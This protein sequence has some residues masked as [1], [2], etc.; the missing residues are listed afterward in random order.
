LLAQ[1][2]PMKKENI[3]GADLLDRT[4][5][6]V[7]LQTGEWPA[8]GPRQVVQGRVSL[9]IYSSHGARVVPLEEGGTLVVGRLPPADVIVRDQNLSRQHARVVLRQGWIWVED[10]DSTNGTWVN[11][12]RIDVPTPLTKNDELAFGSVTASVQD[13]NPADRQCFAW[14]G[15]DDFQV[16]LTSE[17]SRARNFSRAIALLMVRPDRRQP[18]PLNRWFSLLRARLRP[19][20]RAALYSVDT[21]EIALP[22]LTVAQAEELARSMV[23][24]EPVLRCGVGVFPRHASSP[25]E[26]LEVTRVS[27]Q[28]ATSDQ[29]VCSAAERSASGHQGA[30]P[31]VS[32]APVVRSPALKAVYSMAERVASSSI[33]VLVLGETGTGKEHLARAIHERGK[34]AAKP[35]ICVNCG[36]IPS[37]LVESTLFGHERGAFTGAAQQAKGVFESAH[38]GTV[39][40]DEIGELSAVAQAALL[41]VL[42]SKCFTRVGST[43]EVKVDVRVVAA[44][45]RSLEEMVEKGE[46]RADLLYRLNGMKL[47]V[48]PL[49]ERPQDLEPLCDHFV[50]YANAANDCYVQRI[51]P[52]VMD[53]FY[54]YPWPG[55]VRE[56]RNAIERAVVIA[57]DEVITVEDLPEWV[58]DYRTRKGESPLATTPLMTAVQ[59]PDS[60]RAIDLRE[61]L[62][63]YEVSLVGNALEH[64]EWDRGEA[65][66][67][68]N[69]P[70]RTLR[71]KI[72]L[73]G[74]DPGS[75]GGQPRSSFVPGD[76]DT[77]SVE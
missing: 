11:G 73:L 63:R 2:I 50:R 5:P 16:T 21:V 41:R 9:L 58:R 77:T 10:L 52:E 37:Q 76:G 44:T 6:F 54:R 12:K 74:L 65:A 45:H 31:T 18:K 14:G 8:V 51:A 42:E 32:E 24:Q 40:L 36:A 13:L 75:A 28:R 66:R 25:D 35:M 17:V 1:V 56:L 23:A 55:N 4:M 71:R 26:L 30:T 68:L 61:E 48:P 15:H 27:L 70:I 38:G 7:G 62:H 57:L 29:P 3:A 69:L 33:P 60:F 39:M 59:G 46:F 22:E 43:T 20:D 67:L 49:R 53:L 72:Q 34:R 19:F 47:T 64:T